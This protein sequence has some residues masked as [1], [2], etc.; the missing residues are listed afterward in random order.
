MSYYCNIR[1]T[2]GIKISPKEIFLDYFSSISII[3]RSIYD[4]CQT[5]PNNNNVVAN[6]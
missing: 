4:F 3:N 5:F 2:Y 1:Y 6:K